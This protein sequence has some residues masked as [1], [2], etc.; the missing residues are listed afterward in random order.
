MGALLAAA[1][2]SGCSNDAP[3]PSAG[4]VAVQ[5]GGERE[6]GEWWCNEHGLPEEEC[7]RCDPKL[8]AAFKAKGDWCDEHNRPKSQC[9]VCGPSLQVRYAAI[10]KAR[11]GVDPP[12]PTE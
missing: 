3:A 7:A 1:A 11:Y 2:L 12:K 10:Y 4:Q 8:V 5:A 9:F 6:H